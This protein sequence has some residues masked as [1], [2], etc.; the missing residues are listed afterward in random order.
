MHRHLLA[1]GI[2]LAASLPALA[3]DASVMS[4]WDDIDFAKALVANGYPDLAEPLLDLV[5]RSTEFTDQSRGPVTAIRL[6]IWQERA[7]KIEDLLQ[8][9][10][11]LFLVLEDDL[12]FIDAYKGHAA[13]ED[14]QYSLPE[15]C[16]QISWT[17]IAV[18]NGEKDQK[19]RDR[20][21]AQGGPVFV[22]I[23]KSLAKCIAE[24]DGPSEKTEADESKLM[25]ARYSYPRTMYFHALLFEPGS[26][27]RVDLCK[28]AL[29][30]YDEFD[31]DYSGGENPSFLTYYA[32]IDYGMCLKETGNADEACR[33]FDKTIA[34]RESWGSADE[35]SGLWPIPAE[36]HDVADLVA[37]ATLW[38]M[39]VLRDEKKLTDVVAVGADYFAS[40]KTP[41]ALP[42]SMRLAWELAEAQ[43]ATGDA[44]GARAAAESMVR[45]D[46]DGL[47]AQ[48]G[49][50]L[51]SRM[52]K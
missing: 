51:L 21:R 4:G 26:A 35:K 2:V 33:S 43:I 6:L 13:A 45:A 31:L 29:A 19:V 14:V 38:K 42:S 49:R 46:P 11:V 30:E 7:S 1:A 36:A 40:T 28:E 15:L 25:A 10:D 18:V 41:F 3:Q 22:G 37:Y 32:Y 47:G 8:R 23:E 17:V 5:E 48:W 12:K 20:L 44:K 52:G 16:E 39:F 9:K 50:E 34:L 27:E 24:L